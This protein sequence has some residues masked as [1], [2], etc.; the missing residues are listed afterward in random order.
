MPRLDDIDDDLK[1]RRRDVVASLYNGPTYREN[2]YVRRTVDV[3]PGDMASG[4]FADV[5]HNRRPS[6]TTVA[7]LIADQPLSPGSPPPAVAEDAFGLLCQALATTAICG[8]L[9]HPV[10]QWRTFGG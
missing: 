7:G 2:D 8:T 6:W 10:R 9:P 4:V 3:L 1:A 5:Q